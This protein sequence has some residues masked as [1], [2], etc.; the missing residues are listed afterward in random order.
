M[1]K[2]LFPQPPGSSPDDPLTVTAVPGLTTL[3]DVALYRAV[4]GQ[5]TATT[6]SSHALLWAWIDVQKESQQLIQLLQSE[7]ASVMSANHNNNQALLK[8]AESFARQCL[9][10][11]KDAVERMATEHLA[12][13]ANLSDPYDHHHSHSSDHHHHHHGGSASASSSSG[14]MLMQ[15]EALESGILMGSKDTGRR[16]PTQSR[17]D[18]WESPRLMCCDFVWADDVFQA[19]QRSLRSL[20]KHPFLVV[21][22]GGSADA[23]L[24]SIVVSSTASSTSSLP[25]LCDRSAS[26]LVQLLQED[27]PT[28]L[29]QFKKAMEAESVV[30]KRLYLVKC[31]YRAPFR[32]FC[33]AHQSVQRAPSLAMVQSNKN[34]QRSLSSSKEAC[35][36][37][38]QTLLETK[39]LKQSLALERD[40][41]RFEMEMARALVPFSELARFLDSKKAHIKVVSGKVRAQDVPVLQETL[42][43]SFAVVLKLLCYKH[44]LCIIPIHEH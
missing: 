7:S 30:T 20:G 22:S 15:Q 1:F 5:L 13:T 4:E 44:W 11:S 29:W 25:P 33:E 27:I 42:R 2:K 40:C 41:E 35:K 39:E 14:M 8:S 3:L 16:V 24:D 23:A 6:C 26:L 10:A 21:M 18:C 34:N 36:A 17:K 28:R 12:Q 43:V 38:L 31:E 19:C 37:K 9:E 32:A